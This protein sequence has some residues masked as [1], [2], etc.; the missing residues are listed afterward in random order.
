MQALQQPDSKYSP[1]LLEFAM[2]GELNGSM[3]TAMKQAA[4]YF[5]RQDKI[6]QFLF[7]ALTYPMVILL[8]M[9]LALGCHVAIGGASCGAVIS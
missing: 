8:L 7:S 3:E 2:V 6:K 1:V 4:E 5:Q 9:L